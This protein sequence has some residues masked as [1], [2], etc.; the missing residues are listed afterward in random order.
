M[1]PFDCERYA[2]FEWFGLAGGIRMPS[3]RC[4]LSPELSQRRWTRLKGASPFV[5]TRLMVSYGQK[6]NL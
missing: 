3:F 2:S 6:L 5:V 4:I 1:Q